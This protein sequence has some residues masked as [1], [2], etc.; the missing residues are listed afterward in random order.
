MRRATDASGAAVLEDFV[1]P[2]QEKAGT[3]GILM[4]KSQLDHGRG[5]LEVKRGRRASVEYVITV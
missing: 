1:F 2:F 4:P 5:A 3:E